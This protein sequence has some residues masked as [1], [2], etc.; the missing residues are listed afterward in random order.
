MADYPRVPDR[1]VDGAN[2]QG[3][4]SLPITSTYVPPAPWGAPNSAAPA[5]FTPV[6]TPP[7]GPS[8]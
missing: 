8:S 7:P 3:T 4:G 2:D 6:N 5:G 1:S